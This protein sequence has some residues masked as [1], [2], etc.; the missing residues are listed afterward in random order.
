MGQILTIIA[1]ILAIIIGLWKRSSRI[2]EVKRGLAE[3]A[4]KEL[5]DAQKN[6][7]KSDLLDS[8]DNINRVR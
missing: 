7:N 3:K 5:D 4:Q 1:S 2:A 8:W 6:K